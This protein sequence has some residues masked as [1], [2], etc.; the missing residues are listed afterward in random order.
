VKYIGVILGAIVGFL[1][2]RHPI[3]AAIGAALGYAWDQGL[4]R[5]LFVLPT[6]GPEGALVTP[7][8]GL[9]GAVAKADGR[10]SESEVAVTESLVARMGLTPGKRSEAI[11]AFNSGKLPDFDI[12]LAARD[13]RAFCG[14]RSELKLM[15]MDVLIDVAY[16]DGPI[17]DAAEHVLRRV[18]RSIDLADDTLAWL[19]TRRVRPGKVPIADPYAVLGVTQ[20]ASDGEIRK[21]YRKLIAQYHPDKLTARGAAP[22]AIALAEERARAINAAYEQLKELRGIR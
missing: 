19:L 4:L 14:F 6:R 9:A 16:A 21:A 5:G 17:V 18:A 15:L 3:G 1:L 11:Q 10:V 8:F 7:L 13:L 20:D 2:T 12:H 22:E